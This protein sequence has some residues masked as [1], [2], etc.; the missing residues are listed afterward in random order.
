[1]AS[2]KIL[3]AMNAGVS[4]APFAVVSIFLAGSQ[5]LATLYADANGLTQIGNPTELDANGRLHVY[6]VDGFYDVQVTLGTISFTVLNVEHVSASMF[7]PVGTTTPTTSWR[8][9][10]AGDVKYLAWNIVSSDGVFGTL[11]NTGLPGRAMRYGSD[12]HIDW[13]WHDPSASAFPLGSMRTDMTLTAGGVLS[14]AFT[15]PL[16]PTIAETTPGAPS[17]Q[18]FTSGGN[19]A[20]NTYYYKISALDGAG[21]E[22]AGGTEN[23][24]NVT[25]PNGSVSLS[26]SPVPG[27]FAYHVWRGTSSGGENLFYL[28]FGTTFTDTGAA[29]T[30]GT[31]PSSS[32]AYAVK[33]SGTTA[34]WVLAGNFGVGTAAPQRALTVG[35][36]LGAWFE[37][38]LVGPPVLVPSTTG[39]TLAGGTYYYVV[40]AIDVDGGETRAGPEAFCVV[41]GPQGSVP[42]SW[43]PPAGAQAVVSYRVYRGTSPGSESVYFTS[44][45]TSFTDTGAAG[46]SGT[47]PAVTNAFSAG[48]AGG[49]SLVRAATIGPSATKQHALPAVVSDTIALLAAVQTFTNKTLTGPTLTAPSMT[50]PV[51]AT[52]G[53]ASNQQHTLPAVSPDTVAL[54]AAA[55]TLSNKTLTGPVLNT[56]VAS[57][58]GPSSAQQHA[59]PVVSSDTIVLLAAIQTLT[60]KTLT[61]PI[62]GAL[63]PTSGQQHTVP[64]VPSDTFALLAAVQTL[65]NKTLTSPTLTSPVAT[66]IGPAAGQQHTLPAVSPDT[67]ALLAATQTFTNKTLTNPI[68]AALGPTTSNQHTMPNVTADTVV[69]VNAV[70]SLYN[71][72][73]INPVIQNPTYANVSEVQLAEQGSSPGAP[74]AGNLLLY[75]VPGSVL[76]YSIRAKAGTSSQEVILVDNIPIT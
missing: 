43:S 66:T 51:T 9:I 71:K 45:T 41:T 64:G 28:V 21:G 8:L 10:E 65:T 52:I 23:Q 5:T 29:G 22:T 50:T 48:I 75:V 53:P 72:T 20:T 69:L 47:P 56:P 74:G 31:V 13:V 42:M 61:N 44:A 39:G 12:G 15:G 2:Y 60:G 26:W 24:V 14:G 62:I 67:V 11:Q 63:G 27:A 73:F 7:V 32:T 70:Q 76:G 16:N 57:T 59:L 1:M 49:S 55:Q 46:T 34:S 33:F 17:L 18:A 3:K 58:I 6:L 37:V 30:S 25:G 4:S 36:N 38:G 35:P 19:L 40:T 68:I 54:L